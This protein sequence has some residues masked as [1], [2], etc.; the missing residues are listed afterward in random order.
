MSSNNNNENYGAGLAL[1][2]VMAA[3]VLLVVVAY[4]V[5]SLAALVFT[6]LCFCAWERPIAIGSLTIEPHEAKAFVLRGVL[7][8]IALPIVCACVAGMFEVRIQPDFWIHIIIA[9]YAIGSL[10]IALLM[11]QDAANTATHVEIIPPQQIPAPQ[12]PAQP[13]RQ[14]VPFR[15]ASWDDEE[16]GR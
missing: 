6:V 4:V 3:I 10:G 15:F 9:G 13:P 12:A 14:P 8:A 16:E 1:A 11:E 2:F 5:L 7:G